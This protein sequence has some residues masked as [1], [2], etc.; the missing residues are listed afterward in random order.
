[1][2]MLRHACHLA[3][4]THPVQEVRRSRQV[5]LSMS[6]ALKVI[7]GHECIVDPALDTKPASQPCSYDPIMSFLQIKREYFSVFAGAHVQ[8]RLMSIISGIIGNCKAK[9]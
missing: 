4:E 9:R 3:R 2:V 1:M 5:Q 6:D 7:V 8:S